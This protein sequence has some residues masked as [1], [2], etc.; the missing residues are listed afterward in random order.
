MKH[1]MADAG[2]RLVLLGTGTPNAEPDRAGSAL[3]IVADNRP[4]LVDFGPGVVRRAQAACAAG[5]DAL[6]PPNIGHAFL[7]HLHSDHT[8]GF[9]DLILTPWTLGRDKPLQ[10]HGPPGTRAM[11]E[12]LLNAYAAD[13]AERVHG[14]EPANETGCQV[15]IH[16]F[17]AGE[18]HADENVA[19]TAFA[20][21]HG[22]WPAFGFRFTTPD[23]IIVVSGDTAPF[24]GLVDH[25]AGCDILVHEVYS[26]AGF[27]GRPPAWQRYHASVHTS[28][29]QL[30][31]IAAQVQPKLLVL[32]H[33]LHW[34][35]SDE[36]LLAEIRD[37]YDGAVV[38]GKDMDVF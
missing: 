35:V 33:Q 19:V 17:E 2:T 37:R 38:S 10:V 18:V 14:L 4:Y 15:D 23:R 34:G 25:Y 3:A 8:A 11:T 32:V 24:D 21:R 29:R 7:T 5:I 27:A 22:S 30:A 1:A 36:Q 9:A 28:T 20:V 26:E 13:I 12:H 31:A 16:E 6:W